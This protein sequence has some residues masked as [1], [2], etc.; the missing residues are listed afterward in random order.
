MW[1][2]AAPE[3]MLFAVSVRLNEIDDSS[4]SWSVTDETS[5]DS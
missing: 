2:N 3:V 1:K 4:Y 5:K